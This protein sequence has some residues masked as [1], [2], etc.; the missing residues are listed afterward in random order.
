MITLYGLS[1][2]SSGTYQTIYEKIVSTYSNSNGYFEINFSRKNLYSLIIE[3]YY[4]NFFVTKKEI[5]INIFNKNNEV[6]LILEM[7]PKTW[8]NICIKNLPPFSQDDQLY[9]NL[10]YDYKCDVCCHKMSRKFVGIEIDT[11]WFCEIYS[12][13]KVIMSWGYEN[14]F[15]LDTIYALPFDTIAKK[16]FY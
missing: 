13:N 5:D 1:I 3:A 10:N 8:L 16:I 12:Y 9:F 14:N 6:E 15:Y 2:S 11:N 7:H 4:E